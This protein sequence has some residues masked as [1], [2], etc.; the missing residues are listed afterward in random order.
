M[1]LI[2]ICGNEDC[3][4]EFDA[5]TTKPEWE[6]PHCGRIIP[7]KNYPFLTAKFMEAKS[8][9]DTANWHK[10]YE[11][12]LEEAQKLIAEKEAKIEELEAKLKKK[13]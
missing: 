11:E 10:L 4:R 7:N 9:P 2:V 5:E 1:K 12:L 13:K 6:C 8:N 3:N